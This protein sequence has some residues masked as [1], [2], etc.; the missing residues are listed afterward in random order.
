MLSVIAQSIDPNTGKSMLFQDENTK[1]IIN[2]ILE[3]TGALSP[4]ELNA[5][6]L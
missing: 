4:V 5:P 1:M 6:K 2:K 3:A